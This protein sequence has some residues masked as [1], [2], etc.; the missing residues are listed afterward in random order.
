M[1]GPRNGKSGTNDHML[2]PRNGE[3]GTNDHVLGPRND[4]V[5]VAKATQRF[6]REPCTVLRAFS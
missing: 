6:E 5:S 1:L 2:G 3:S 4:M